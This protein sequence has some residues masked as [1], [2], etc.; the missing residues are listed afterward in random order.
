MVRIEVEVELVAV[1][2]TVMEERLLLIAKA[3]H[4][5]TKTNLATPTQA[6]ATAVAAAVPPTVPQQFHRITLV[7]VLVRLLVV[8]VRLWF[9]G[10]R[11]FSGVWKTLIVNTAGSSLRATGTPTTALRACGASTWMSTRVTA[12]LNAVG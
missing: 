12:Q 6:A 4:Q 2:S 5:I 10:R 11:S 8:L 3:T 7:L 1:G 9:V